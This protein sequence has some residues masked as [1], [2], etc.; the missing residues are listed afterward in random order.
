MV[1]QGDESV[2]VVIARKGVPAV[3]DPAE[4]EL[5]RWCALVGLPKSPECEVMGTWSRDDRV[6][7]GVI[8]YGNALMLLT[9]RYL[10]CS[11]RGVGSNF[12]R[13]IPPNGSGLG[14][15]N[16]GWRYGFILDLADIDF[17][18]GGRRALG[19]G[20]SSAGLS[21]TS[22]NRADPE[23]DYPA[24]FKGCGEFAVAL[25][26]AVL[27]ARQQHE[28]EAVRTRAAA[29]AATD[30]RSQLLSRWRPAQ[31]RV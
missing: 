2:Q 13:V 11:I 26:D 5:S 18:R 15:I 27:L 24:N 10:R 21:V 25:T 8:A 3:F 17:I 30:Y 28:D 6:V 29:V 19:F 7:Q 12:A 22:V 31:F 20:N 16:K 9:S 23:W 4:Q 14:N 1:Y